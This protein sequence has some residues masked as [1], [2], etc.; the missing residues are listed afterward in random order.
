MS[1]LLTYIRK[2]YCAQLGALQQGGTEGYGG[3]MS[4]TLKSMGDLLCIVPPRH[5]YHNIYF[6]WLVPPT[7]KIVAAPLMPILLIEAYIYTYIY[8]NIYI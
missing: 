1:T 6:D 3:D 4:P 2:H 7:Y 5:F 8:I